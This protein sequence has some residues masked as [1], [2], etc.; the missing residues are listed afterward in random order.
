MQYYFFSYL[1][2]IFQYAVL[3]FSQQYAVLLSAHYI[4]STVFSSS[5]CALYP[6]F[7]SMKTVRMQSRIEDRLEHKSKQCQSFESHA[8]QV[9]WERAPGTTQTA[10][11]TNDRTYGSI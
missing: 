2:C 4:S 9:S 3:F 5:I 8:S 7:Q 1:V 11:R 10:Q 6:V